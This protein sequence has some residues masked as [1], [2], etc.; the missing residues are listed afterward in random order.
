MIKRIAVGLLLMVLLF[1]VGVFFVKNLISPVSTDNKLVD[2]LIPKGTSVAQIGKKLEDMNLIKSAVAFKFIVQLTG[3]QSR[4]QA[5]EFELSQSLSLI[6]ILDSLK[7]GPKEIWVTIP[8]GLRRE[9]VAQKF[10]KSLGKDE[11]FIDEFM[12]LTAGKEG[13]LF[14]DT[15]LFP[16]STTAV[17]VVNKMTSTFEK[18]I[19]DIAFDQ[20]IVASMLERETF[21]DSEKSIVAGILYKRLNN[22]WPLQVDATLQYAKDSLSCKGDLDCDY[23]KPVYSKDKE[24]SSPFNTYKYKGL[25]PSPIANPGLSSLTAAI[26]PE[27][28]DYWYYIHD[29]DGKIHFAKT[30]EEHNENIRKYLD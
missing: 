29:N 7:K 11:F 8:E 14:P 3:S 12:S 4:I 5:G 9:E 6:Q 20:V 22:N 16:K 24:I 15:Y 1:V 27:E 10:A 21:A 2:F 25:P 30:L 13:Y 28:S 17:L 19:N 23:W 18:K 26:N